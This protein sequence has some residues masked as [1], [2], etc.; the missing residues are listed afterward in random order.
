MQ[1][2]LCH[3]KQFLAEEITDLDTKEKTQGFSLKDKTAAVIGMGGLGCNI[4]VHLAGAG[5]KRIFLV[6]FDTVS[7]SNLNRQFL[8]KADDIGK[9]KVKT[10]GEFLASFEPETE[11]VCVEKKIEQESDL[12]VLK[13]CDIIFSAL[14]NSKARLT[15]EKFAQSNSIPLSVGGID[16]FYGMVYLYLPNKSLPP[17]Q[18][19][20]CQK[21]KASFSVSAVAGVIGSIQASTGISYL[22]REDESLSKKLFIYDEN[23]IST[24]NLK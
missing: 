20:L 16:G 15:V 12:S 10:A 5:F 23:Q 14:D 21:G 22:L 8:Y 7:K 1:L 4:A 13:G 17:S 19:G 9:S 2:K 24:L 3:R 11:F 6:D 18:T